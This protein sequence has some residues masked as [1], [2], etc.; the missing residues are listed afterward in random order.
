[1]LIKKDGKWVWEDDPTPVKVLNKINAHLEYL[2]RCPIV[3]SPVFGECF[4]AGDA[5]FW[6]YTNLLY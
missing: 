4:D 2:S 3:D 5:L 6:K 1:M